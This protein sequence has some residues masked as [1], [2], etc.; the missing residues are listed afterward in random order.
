MNGG[1]LLVFNLKTDAADDVLGFTTDWVN[2]LAENFSQVVVI[3]M[4]RGR[5]AVRSNVSVHSVGKE[6]GYSELRRFFEFYRLLI[7]ATRQQRFV[8]CFS[9]MNPLFA[10]M[11][12][13]ILKLRGIPIM[14]W[15]AHKSVTGMLRLSTLLVDRIVA[16]TPS[17][18]RIA[19]PKLRIIGQGINLSKFTPADRNLSRDGREK[20]LVIL[21]VGRVSRI[22]NLDLGIKALALALREADGKS[23]KYRIVGGPLTEDDKLHWAELVRLSES[24]GVAESVEFVGQCSFEAVENEYKIADLFLNMSGTGSLDKT[25]LEAMASGIPV[26]TSNEAVR[27]ILPPGLVHEVCVPAGREAVLAERLMALSRKS[28][29]ERDELGLKLREDVAMNHSL[30]ALS[31][32][33]TEE[34]ARLAETR[35]G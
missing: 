33:L 5:L 10:V 35:K 4:S 23:W 34:A 16:S 2:A 8:A 28:R 19:T 12:W 18:F 30:Q 11:A 9:H 7:A 24:L 22:K 17:G 6:K 13:P 21:T 27:E 32:R 25:I 1:N 26:L 3:T 15:Y 31:L 29:A 20:T 14:L